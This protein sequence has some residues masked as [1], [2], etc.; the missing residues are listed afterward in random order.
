MKKIVS[1]LLD[2]LADIIDEFYWL[3][4]VFGIIIAGRGV[5]RLFRCEHLFGAFFISFAIIIYGVGI[6]KITR[7]RRQAGD[8]ATKE[9]KR[10]NQNIY[11]YLVVGFVLAIILEAYLYLENH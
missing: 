3:L 4:W 6:Y 9:D 8:A 7:I 2:F 10:R 5:S 11:L 1:E